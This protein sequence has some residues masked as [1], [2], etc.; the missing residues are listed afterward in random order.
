MDIKLI[1]LI[2]NCKRTTMKS[3]YLSI[4]LLLPYHANAMEN[5]ATN[6]NETVKETLT[7]A[8]MH[9]RA[10][11]SIASQ[12]LVSKNAAERSEGLK[13]LFTFHGDTIRTIKIICAQQENKLINLGNLL[14]N[15]IRTNPTLF[16]SFETGNF[17]FEGK[18]SLVRG[19]PL[20]VTGRDTLPT[21]KEYLTMGI[22][23]DLLSDITTSDIAQAFTAAIQEA[24]KN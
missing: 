16:D 20:L 3:L 10:S 14:P 12:Y 22:P 7:D 17:A 5:N 2:T 19:K 13:H 4:F 1:R 11:L 21:S 24:L 8:Q 6:P 9:V 18:S 15:C 23:A